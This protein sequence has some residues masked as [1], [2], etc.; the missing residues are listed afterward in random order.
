MSETIDSPSIQDFPPTEEN[1]AVEP[2]TL[3]KKIR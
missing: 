1:S 3:D 2:E